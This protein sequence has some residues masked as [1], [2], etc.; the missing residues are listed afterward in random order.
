MTDSR[1]RERALRTLLILVGVGQLVVG[2][3]MA[4]V[5]GPF[6]EEVGPYGTRNDHYTR[7]L[8]TF[9]LALGVLLL[10]ALRRPSWRVPVLAYAALQYGLHALNHLVDVGEADPK[11]LGPANLVSLVLIAAALTWG[12]WTSVAEERRVRDSAGGP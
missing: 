7:D 2:A 3:L 8:A 10:A 12:L 5:P 4:I 6:F 1:G 11:S 9:T